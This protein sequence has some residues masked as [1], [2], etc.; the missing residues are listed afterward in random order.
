MQLNSVPCKHTNNIVKGFTNT[1][2]LPAIISNGDGSNK[3]KKYILW[4]S[5]QQSAKWGWR[6]DKNKKIS[7]TSVN[8]V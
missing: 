4:Q 1:E 3:N 7:I 2:H 5:I 8:Q 6:H